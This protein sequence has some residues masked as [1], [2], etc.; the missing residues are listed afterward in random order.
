M[1]GMHDIVTLAK[2]FSQQKRSQKQKLFSSQGFL[3][4]KKRSLHSKIFFPA[5]ISPQQRK[6][7][8]QQNIFSSQ[9]FH[10]AKKIS[11]NKNFFL[12]QGFLHRKKKRFLENKNFF[13]PKDFFP[14]KKRF[15]RTKTFCQ[16][17]ISSQQKN[18]EEKVFKKSGETIFFLS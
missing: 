13:L 11:K 16:P 12:S 3:S 14:A 10:P 18:Q 7:S 5:R 6:I 17:R 1:T 15:L 9:G 4:A 2:D 8:P